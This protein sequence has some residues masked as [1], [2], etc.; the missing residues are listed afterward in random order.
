MFFKKKRLERENAG[1]REKVFEM[2]R[3]NADLQVETEKQSR[4]KE[5]FR[6]KMQAVSS[7]ARKKEI[8]LRAKVTELE[9]KITYINEQFDKLV[10]REVGRAEEI[11][12]L[13][14]GKEGWKICKASVPD[15]IPSEALL[16]AVRCDKGKTNVTFMEGNPG[17]RCIEE[18]PEDHEGLFPA[19]QAAEPQS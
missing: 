19:V 3:R 1:L 13:L 8:E 16:L 9:E 4:L 15:A 2:A 18:L 6:A 10:A 5:F 14:Y 17:V 11:G 7:N 12:E